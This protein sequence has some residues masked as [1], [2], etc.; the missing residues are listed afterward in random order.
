MAAP[1]E[2]DIWGAAR[3]GLSRV[4]GGSQ[5]GPDMTGFW[6]QTTQ[7]NRSVQGTTH[8]HRFLLKHSCG[9]QW[10]LWDAS[11]SVSYGNRRTHVLN[12]E[13]LECSGVSS[14]CL[15]VPLR[16][17]KKIKNNHTTALRH[18]SRCFSTTIV[19]V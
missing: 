8:T 5:V 12:N 16:Q 2:C 6:D 18:T 9:N 11:E 19:I 14:E 4:L 17:N 15:C 7:G 3:S 13:R 1:A 10:K